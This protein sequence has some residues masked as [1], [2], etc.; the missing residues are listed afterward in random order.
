[1]PPLQSPK[2]P[3]QPHVRQTQRQ[4]S[5]AHLTAAHAQPG[6]ALED[7]GALLFDLAHA[8]YVAVAGEAEECGTTCFDETALL[9]R[10]RAGRGKEELADDATWR[11]VIVALLLLQDIAELLWLI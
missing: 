6:V 1:M 11:A 2:Q 10:T 8:G 5:D 7:D 3:V 9:A 4:T